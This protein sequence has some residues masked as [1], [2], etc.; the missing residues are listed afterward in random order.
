MTIQEAHAALAHIP[1][2]YEIQFSSC[3]YGTILEPKHRWTVW[4]AAK[5]KHYSAETLRGA[6]QMAV[7]A[8]HV[9]E[10]SEHDEALAEVERDIVVDDYYKF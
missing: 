4:L 10:Y 2:T 3:R 1:G 5:Q 7:E 9:S 8:V 6:I